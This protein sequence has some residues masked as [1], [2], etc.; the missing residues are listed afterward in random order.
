MKVTR[1]SEDKLSAQEWLFWL[2]DRH[3]ST[4]GEIALRLNSYAELTR[5]TP[6]HKFTVAKQGFARWSS[7]LK[8]GRGIKAADIPFPD[9]VVA[10]AKS[11][12]TITLVKPEE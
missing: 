10:E 12:I 1:V 2:S 5:A 8:G 6:R 7:F 4:G 9:D 11:R 3:S